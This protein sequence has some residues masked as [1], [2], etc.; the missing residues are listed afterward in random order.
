MGGGMTGLIV[1]SFAGGGGAS[2]GIEAALGR[3]GL[4]PGRLDGL[5][6]ADLAAIAA[7]TQNDLK[8][9]IVAGWWSLDATEQP[10]RV[11]GAMTTGDPFLA[12]RRLGRGTVAMTAYTVVLAGAMWL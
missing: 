3:L 6:D 4:R 7:L 12:V 5:Y 10:Q 1:D 11:E 9:A 8:R 2:T